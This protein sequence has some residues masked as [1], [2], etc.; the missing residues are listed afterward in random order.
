MCLPKLW[1]EKN[2]LEHGISISVD[3]TS[4]GTIVL[5][6]KYD[7]EG[8]PQKAIITLFP[9]LDRVIIENIYWVLTLFNLKPKIESVP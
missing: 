5:N 8:T 9:L 4:D 6:P 3:E 7:A 1:A 2:G